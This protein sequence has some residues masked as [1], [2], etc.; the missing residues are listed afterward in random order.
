MATRRP[1]NSFFWLSDIEM[2]LSGLDCFLFTIS[3]YK[4]K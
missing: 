2:L 4:L 1:Q 3:G